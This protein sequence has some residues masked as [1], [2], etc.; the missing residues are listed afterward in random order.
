MEP[1]AIL[2]T[3]IGKPSAE[4]IQM[5]GTPRNRKMGSATHKRNGASLIFNCF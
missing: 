1:N 5:Q 2:R 3:F 4:K